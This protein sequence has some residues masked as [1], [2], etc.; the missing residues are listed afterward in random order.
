M[1]RK[2]KTMKGFTRSLMLCLL[3]LL[4]LATITATPVMAHDT[5]GDTPDHTVSATACE[6]NDSADRVRSVEA[7]PPEQVSSWP[8]V[9]MVSWKPVLYRWDGVRMHVWKEYTA[10]TASAEVTPDGLKSG[11]EFGW[12]DNA[13][14]DKFSSLT[15]ANLP[16]GSYAVMNVMTW[17]SDGHVHKEVSPN[18]CGN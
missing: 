6:Y 15:F 18:W 4:V 9:D 16:A 13:T 10:V 2:V 5:S 14:D 1:F 17:K 11:N 8:K 3:S 7:F 12:R